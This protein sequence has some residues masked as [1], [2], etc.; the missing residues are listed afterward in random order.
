M[1]DVHG[2]GTRQPCVGPAKTFWLHPAVS[3]AGFVF[4]IFLVAETKACALE[5]IEAL[6]NVA[7]QR[8]IP[9]AQ[10]L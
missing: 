10:D 2:E 3:R 9:E 6:W 4:T 7:K 1:Q 5:D 8:P